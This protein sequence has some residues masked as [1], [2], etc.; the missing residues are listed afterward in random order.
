MER[1]AFEKVL[2]IVLLFSLFAH[3]IVKLISSMKAL[4][5]LIYLLNFIDS[6]AL[7][8]LVRLGLLLVRLPRHDQR[9]A[10]N[11]EEEIKTM[12]SLGSLA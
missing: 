7:Q 11:P 10:L 12:R 9:I 8:K 5:R 2:P 6:F 4:F 1:R 3:Y